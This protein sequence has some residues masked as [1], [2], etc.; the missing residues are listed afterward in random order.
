MKEEVLEKGNL[1]W[2]HNTAIPYT[3]A[4]NLSKYNN[5]FFLQSSPVERV[6]LVSVPRS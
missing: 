3:F 6:L 4:Y 1:G 5:A 2:G